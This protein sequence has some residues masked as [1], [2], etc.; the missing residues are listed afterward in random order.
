MEANYT[1]A[2]DGLG[3]TAELDQRAA[4]PLL[5][6]PVEI[7]SN[8][9]SVI[10]AAGRAFGGWHALAPE[11]VAPI[12]PRVVS[13][14][15]HPADPSLL[16]GAPRPFVQRIHGG[17]FLASDGVNMLTA[18]Y[19]EGRALAFVA[20]EL[21][22]HEARL[23][24]NVLELLALLLVTQHDRVPVHTG[25][26]VRNGLAIL[27]AGRS[28]AGKSTLCYACLRD[29]FQLLAEDV[30]YASRAP[31]LRLWGVPWQIHLL[32]D[33]V[34]FFPELADI[35]AEV[36]ANGKF[37]L[38]V[39]TAHFGPARAICHAERAVVCVV[40]RH[41]AAE[42]LLEPIDPAVA[43]ATLSGNRESGF[44]LYDGTRAVAEALAARGAYR[45]TVGSDLA[46][47]TAAL[48]RL[49]DRG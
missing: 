3:H 11:L 34:R 30:V 41:A 28:T 8:S 16:A 36:Q 20:P 22:Q 2:R 43:V 4:F 32:P 26:V 31:A 48:R 33:A 17:C 39:D 18:Q 7:R 47:A 10:A 49:A 44:D 12:E 6:V 23:R 45:L 24:Y 15:V 42:A 27:L 25:A 40:E 19:D 38:A 5:G 37:K 46:C 29:G 1:P 35:P 9:A 13:V 14:V 21:L